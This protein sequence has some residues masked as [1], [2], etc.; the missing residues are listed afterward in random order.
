MHLRYLASAGWVVTSP[1]TTHRGTGSYQEATASVGAITQPPLLRPQDGMPSPE[2]VFPLVTL[3]STRS[4]PAL[5]Q[6]STASL[7]QLPHL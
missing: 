2:L 3:R 6:A 4:S 1:I 5:F 7:C